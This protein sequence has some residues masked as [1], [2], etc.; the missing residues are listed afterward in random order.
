[1]SHTSNKQDKKNL[2]EVENLKTYYPIKGGFFRKTVGNVKAVDNVSFTIRNGE[3]LG[4]VGESGC[5]K[6]TTGR[7]ILRLLNPT[8]GK[9]IFNGQDITTLGGKS[10][11]EIRK[12]IQ[13][14]FQDPYATLNPMQM[15]GNVISEP[16]MNYTNKSQKALKNEVLELLNKVGLPEDAYYKYAHEF[17]GGQRQR[18]GIARALAL[19]PKLIIADEPVSALDVSVQSQVL[20]L[21]KELQE[22]FDLTFLFIAHDLSVIKHMSDRIGVM[23]LGNIIEIGDKDSVYAEPLHP[24]TQAL[25]S[26]IPSPDPRK[27]KERIILQGDVPSPANPPKGCP[28]HPRCPKA[29]AECALTKPALKEVKPGHRV[30]CHLYN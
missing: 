1:M 18:I 11:R 3:T 25:I 21:L 9:I 14:V 7:T 24:Y 26:A 5:G 30:A 10:L 17:S 15:I 13:M 27:K 12:D 19:R 6:S 22:E 20:N 29:F 23:Y 8:D 4:L 28:F 16:I 2:L